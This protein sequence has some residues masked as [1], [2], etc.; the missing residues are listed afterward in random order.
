MPLVGT[1]CCRTGEPAR[2]DSCINCAKYGAPEPCQHPFPLIM[3][4]RDNKAGRADAMNTLSTTTLLG[5]V[6]FDQL[7]EAHDYYEPPSD[8]EARFKGT[9]IHS[10]LEKML[11]NESDL[12][13]EVRFFRE[14]V[15]EAGE[16]FLLSG[17][18][19]VLLPK[20]NGESGY[21]WI[22]DGKSAGR[23]KMHPDMEASE[24]HI[25]QVNIYRWIVGGGFYEEKVLG[26]QMGYS[27]IRKSVNIPINRAT[28][29]YVGDNDLQEVEVPCWP[30][31]HVESMIGQMIAR[32]EGKN[33]AP[34]LPSKFVVKRRTGLTEEVRH[35]KCDRCPLREICDT[36]PA[37]GVERPNFDRP[38]EEA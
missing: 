15:T 3:A 34:I 38:D 26:S 9:L 14:F 18:P 19:D 13:S 5:C 25:R 23:R 16:S 12:I 24:D 6:R 17:Q 7:S 8:F 11:E 35:W 32:F 28:I 2:F 29:W 37:E 36:Y 27:A 33:L 31:A 21:G 30:L 22:I 4:M 1:V 10:G 20:F